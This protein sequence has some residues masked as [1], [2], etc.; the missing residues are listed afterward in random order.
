MQKITPHLWYDTQAKEAAEFYV[1]TFGDKSK[2]SS[3]SVIHDTPSGDAETVSFEIWGTPF[4]AISAGPYFTFNP[5]VSF[6]VNFDPSQIKNAA[7]KIDH[8]WNTLTKGGKVLME[9]GAYPFSKRYG[10]VQDKYSLSWQ[11]I[12][13]EPEGEERPLIMP[14]L[15][16]TGNVYGKAKEAGEFYTSV[17]KHSK[18]GDTVPYGPGREPDDKD[19]L[20]FSEFKLYDQWFVA[21]DSAVQHDS[22]FNEAVSFI[23]HCADQKEV[24][25]YWQQLSAV[26]EAEQ[27]GWLKDKFGVSWQIVPTVLDAMMASKDPQKVAQVTKAFLQ[28]KK[29]DIAALE[30]AYQA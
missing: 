28:M 6:M 24:D 13:S 5:S 26:P 7:Q 23:V 18:M 25:Y 16:F 17:F 27:C 8:V 11:L 12:L 22:S 21:M 14:S 20:M 1:D 3:V 10:W 29:F 15:L 19:A 30:K 2:V 4:M 9:L